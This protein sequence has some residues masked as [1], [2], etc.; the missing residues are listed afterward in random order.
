MKDKINSVLFVCSGDVC[1]SPLAKAIATK[2]A[3]DR[4][5]VLRI[6]SAATSNC[7]I[8]DAPCVNAIKVAAM[9]SL[10]ISSHKARLVDPKLDNEFDLVIGFDV[11]NIED[12]KKLGITN[13]VKLGNFGLNG[14]DI[15]DPYFSNSL[16]N[17][18]SMYDLI[19]QALEGI[20]DE[21]IAKAKQ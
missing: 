4:D 2:M 20:F 18:I 21:F 7:H 9:N 6:D 16:A 15:L 3:K 11:N 5:A 14:N 1:R 13:V 8:G 17:F 10:D 12:L 19:K